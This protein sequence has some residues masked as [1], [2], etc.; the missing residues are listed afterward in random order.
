MNII[1]EMKNE[2][3]SR[4]MEK[5][6]IMKNFKI[7]EL[8]IKNIY[9]NSP[10]LLHIKENDNWLLA[11]KTINNY[12]CASCESYIGDLKN[13]NVYLTWN[14]IPSHENKKDR[15]GNGFSRMFQLINIDLTFL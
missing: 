7:L 4:Y 3:P 1:E 13:K 11:K 14:K 5:T 9:E 8:Q 15:M 6:E 10:N 12:L 2:I